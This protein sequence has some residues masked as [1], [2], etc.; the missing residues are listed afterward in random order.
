MFSE[1]SGALG[2]QRLW[3][4]DRKHQVAI[5]GQGPLLSSLLSHVSA[6]A[7]PLRPD[8]ANLFSSAVEGPS[9]LCL[10]WDLCLR[11]FSSVSSGVGEGAGQCMGLVC[12]AQPKP[13]LCLL[14]PVILKSILCHSRGSKRISDA[15][16]SKCLSSTYYAQALHVSAI[17]EVWTDCGRSGAG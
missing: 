2:C 12:C 11:F 9:A 8:L 16:F 10:W 13:L 4:Q 6:A 14:F 3:A 1:V 5:A 17:V 15:S 7:P